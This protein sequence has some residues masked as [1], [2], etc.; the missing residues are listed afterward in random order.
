MYEN[1][2]YQLAYL[3][4]ATNEPRHEELVAI[5]DA[6]V[7]NNEANHI[8]GFLMY[9][10]QSFFQVIEGPQKSID[11]LYAKLLQDP[12]HCRVTQLLKSPIDHRRFA[13]WSMAFMHYDK[14]EDVPVKGYS[15]YLHDYL[16]SGKSQL[17]FVESD[18]TAVIE[19]MIDRMREN[20][21]R[22]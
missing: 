18:D 22:A 6:S 10:E 7:T 15:S 4:A 1:D 12:R 5:L 2:L 14:L 3:S 11:E 8:T 13:D 17:N 9:A 19:Y 16:S 21:I 20:L